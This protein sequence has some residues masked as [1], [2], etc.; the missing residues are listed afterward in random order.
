MFIQPLKV[1]GS[2]RDS[3]GFSGG[4]RLDFQHPYGSSQL[5]KTPI[6]GILTSSSSLLGYWMQIV[7]N[8]IC[9]Q[10]TQTHENKGEKGVRLG[11][12]VGY[13]TRMNKAHSYIWSGSGWWMPVLLGLGW[14]WRLGVSRLT[15][16]SKFQ[17][18]L[19]YKRHWVSYVSGIAGGSWRMFNFSSNTDIIPLKEREA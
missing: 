2:W 6:P 8:H 7:H 3:S 17:G 4:S 16:V 11:L 19:D 1:W 18:S 12:L 13:M 9:S 15:L 14:N 10:N 5:S